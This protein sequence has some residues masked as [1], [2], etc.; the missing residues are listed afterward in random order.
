M[1]YNL[2]RFFCYLHFIEEETESLEGLSELPKVTHLGCKRVRI[3][4]NFLSSESELL[5]IG[6]YH[7]P[8]QRHSLTS[9]FLL[10]SSEAQASSH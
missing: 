10:L 9:S 1:L 8:D 5:T 3:E 4:L 6:L 2:L 7:L